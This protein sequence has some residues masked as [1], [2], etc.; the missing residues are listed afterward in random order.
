MAFS[1]DSRLLATGS[2]DNTTLV[3]NTSEGKE[4]RRLTGQ[5]RGVSCVGFTRRGKVLATG[6]YDS[7]I[8]LWD[9]RTGKSLRTL[10]ANEAL[11]PNENPKLIHAI[12]SLAFSNDERLLVAA[13]VNGIISA[14]NAATGQVSLPLGHECQAYTLAFSPKGG[15]LAAAGNRDAIKFWDTT[16]WAEQGRIEIADDRDIRMAASH[17]RIFL[18]FSPDG[19]VLASGNENFTARLDRPLR[20]WDVATRRE[21]CRFGDFRDSITGIA[22]STDGKTLASASTTGIIKLWDAATGRERCRLQLEQDGL[23]CPTFSP[24]GKFLA[25]VSHDRTVLLWDVAALK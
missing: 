18:A 22:F 19:K 2:R 16:Q 1:P 20:L 3:W 4:P 5:K 14:W 7:T 24:D 25:T 21:L 15:L 9:P 13:D 12:W 11:N 17:D 6:S 23:K 8:M 10:N